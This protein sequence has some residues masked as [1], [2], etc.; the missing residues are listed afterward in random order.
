M[1]KE[2]SNRSLKKG[3]R[4][5]SDLNV[6]ITKGSLFNKNAIKTNSKII[7]AP[8]TANKMY[9]AADNG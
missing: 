6:S 5:F 2:F 7:K 8:S 1:R 9:F 4:S 3:I